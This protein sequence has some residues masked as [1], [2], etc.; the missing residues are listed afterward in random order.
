MVIHNLNV[1]S[2]PIRPA[3]AHA[4]L[5]INAYAVL[6]G[7]IAS[8]GLQSVAWRNAEVFQ[9]PRDLK[10]PQLSARY[11]S[12]GSKPF[13]PLAFRDD[14]CVGAFER[15]DHK[16]IVTRYVINVKRDYRVRSGSHK[17]RQA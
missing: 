7:P 17:R 15:M 13:N 2:T 6:A 14:F 9:S 11:D 1:L 3:E 5:I 12:D 8:Q 4:E 16:P 10:L